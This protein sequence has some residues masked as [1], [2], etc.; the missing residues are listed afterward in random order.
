MRKEIISLKSMHR[1]AHQLE[2]VGLES[3]H[4]L[5]RPPGPDF[6]HHL[7]AVCFHFVANLRVI[8]GKLRAIKTSALLTHLQ[9]LR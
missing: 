8:M 3:S 2:P 5:G 7:Y 4:V 1:S 9:L 6:I